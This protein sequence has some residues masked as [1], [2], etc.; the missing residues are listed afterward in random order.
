MVFISVWILV[1]KLALEGFSFC[2]YKYSEGQFQEEAVQFFHIT[3]HMGYLGTVI[4]LVLLT[5]SSIWQNFV[6]SSG[7]IK[8]LGFHHSQRTEFMRPL[9]N[10]RNHVVYFILNCFLLIWSVWQCSVIV[11]CLLCC[12]RSVSLYVLQMLPPPLWDGM[13]SCCSIFCF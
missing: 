3:F 1:Q 12:C 11:W 5:L 6:V 9:L 8:S 13:H 4:C 10:Q 7:M 2:F